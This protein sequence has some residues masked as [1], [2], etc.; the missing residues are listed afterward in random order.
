MG[1][2]T[3]ALPMSDMSFIAVIWS[4]THNISEECAYIVLISSKNL[5][6]VLHLEKHLNKT[7]LSLFS[8]TKLILK[9]VIRI[10]LVVIG[11]LGHS[12]CGFNII[13]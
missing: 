3:I 13:Y 9:N 1:T 2:C 8:Q 11:Y 10:N 7:P 12:L 5:D 6:L 4:L